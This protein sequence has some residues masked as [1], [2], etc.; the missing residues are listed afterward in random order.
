MSCLQGF[1][2]RPVGP[3]LGQ[4][5]PKRKNCI[6]K[7]LTL[8]SDQAFQSNY[9]ARPCQF[10]LSPEFAEDARLLYVVSRKMVQI[11]LF[12]SRNRDR[13]LENGYVDTGQG[14]GKVG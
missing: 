14:V 4:Q 11:N 10:D 6:N 2:H 1:E 9:S 5:N 8:S 7:C 13:D 3:R 12:P